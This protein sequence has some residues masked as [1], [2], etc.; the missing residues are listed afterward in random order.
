V[1]SLWNCQQEACFAARAGA[2]GEV[3]AV[4]RIGK[5]GQ[6]DKLDLTGANQGLQAEV[7]VA[8]NLSKFDVRCEGESLRFIFAFTLEDPPTDNIVPP[9]V[10]FLPPNRFELIFRRVKPHNSF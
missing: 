4:V 5:D 10:R 7:R 2:P 1:L 6:V 3:Y 9:G 8:M